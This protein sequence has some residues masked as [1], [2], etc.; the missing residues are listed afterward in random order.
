VH[1]I[2]LHVL[3]ILSLVHSTLLHP[4][5]AFCLTDFSTTVE[6]TIFRNL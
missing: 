4:Q 3:F 1:S 5:Y 6:M 2:L